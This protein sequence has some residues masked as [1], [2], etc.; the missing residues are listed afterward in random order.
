MRLSRR[1]G[2]LRRP[3]K[4]QTHVHA[5]LSNEDFYFDDETDGT[6]HYWS[7]QCSCGAI[8]FVSE[9]H[10]FGS[11]QVTTTEPTCT[12]EGAGGYLCIRCA[13]ISEKYSIAPLG[14]A[15]KF[16]PGKSASCTSG[17]VEAGYTCARC[18]I[19][20]SGLGYIA[21][22]GHDAVEDEGIAPTCVQAGCTSGTRCSRC[23]VRL[24][25][26]LYLDPLGHDEVEDK[27]V[28]PRCTLPGRSAGSHCAR[29]NKVL[30]EQ[31]EI[32]AKGHTY[33]SYI[34]GVGVLN[35]Y[36]PDCGAKLT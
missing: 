13:K 29:C 2:L 4:G 19:T 33:Y 26:L 30:V 35:D 32:P 28:E 10:N 21:P 24:S 17:G 9:P 1:A 34:D 20:L 14:H 7:E 36:C 16:A 15:P 31:K 18:G 3:E 25:G 27:A 12:E 23:D 11:E 8:R 22:L 6:S 5:F